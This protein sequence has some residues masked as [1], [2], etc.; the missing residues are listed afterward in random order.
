LLDRVN[1]EWKK[2]DNRV[3]GHT[4]HSPPIGLG[5]REQHFT[6][7]WRVFVVDRTKLSDSFQDNKMDL[8]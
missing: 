8:G 5:V 2:I 1:K 7:D 4:L 6:E 3:I